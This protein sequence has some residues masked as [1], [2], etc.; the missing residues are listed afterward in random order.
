MAKLIK[1]HA[2]SPPSWIFF[3]LYTRLFYF[4]LSSVGTKG[5]FLL[6]KDNLEIKKE[7]IVNIT[8][9]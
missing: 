4:F 1:F 7:R 9:D 6:E 3:V 8:Y 5:K 2:I